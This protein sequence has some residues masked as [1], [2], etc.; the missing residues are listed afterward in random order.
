M[1]G[2]NA[3]FQSANHNQSDGREFLDD[4]Y[5]CS[6]PPQ[7][8]ECCYKRNVRPDALLSVEDAVNGLNAYMDGN[9]L[10]R[11]LMPHNAKHVDLDR[12]HDVIN[13]IRHQLTKLRFDE[14]GVHT[15]KAE[16][17]VFG[18]KRFG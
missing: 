7:P 13:Q 17:Y 11:G 10:I 15:G 3:E 12:A 16:E 5:E 9:S 6:C 4:G 1:A 8:A 14:V 18:R 2:F